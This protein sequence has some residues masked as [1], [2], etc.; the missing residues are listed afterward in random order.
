[1]EKQ[2]KSMLSRFKAE[3][4][5][6]SQQAAQ[7]GQQMAGGV[8][9]TTTQIQALVSA[10][11]KLN[12]DGSIT[13]T[14]KGFDALNR[15]ITE[16]YKNGQLLTRTRSEDSS[17][18]KD[19]NEANRLYSEQVSLL[20]RVYALKTQRLTAKDGSQTAVDLDS[21][22]A[23]TE[24]LIDANNQLI[25]LLNGQAIS[26]SKLVNLSQEE[27]ALSQKYV[28]AQIAQQEKLNALNAKNTNGSKELAQV[29]ASYKALTQAQRS[30]ITAVKNGDTASQAYWQQAQSAAMREIESIESKVG[31]LNIEE[32]VRTKILNVI[33]QAKDAEQTHA[34]NLENLNGSTSKLDESLGRIASRLL[35]MATTMLVLRGLTS[36]WREAT[37]YAQTFYDQLNEIRIVTGKTEAEA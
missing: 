37:T 16:V 27:A 35:Q 36:L 30:Y 24:R 21:Q 17:L 29:Q 15:S 11:Q 5:N 28:S 9:G 25:G 26:R 13:E 34:R 14:K 33:Q 7:A 32:S 23:D 12:K 8:A 10:T 18:T 2:I 20:K 4:Q 1:M 3:I 19:I 6:A 31:S 22:I